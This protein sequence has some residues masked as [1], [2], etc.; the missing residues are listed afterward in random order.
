MEIVN[1]MKKIALF[2]VVASFA[3]AMVACQAAVGKAGAD[4]TDGQTG[5]QGIPGPQG[6]SWDGTV[7]SGSGWC[8]SHP[9]GKAFGK[10]CRT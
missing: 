1:V 4:G 9:F 8:G 2:L 6:R 7:H 10:G 3:V 5:L